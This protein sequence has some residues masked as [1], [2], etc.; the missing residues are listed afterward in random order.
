RDQVP[1]DPI[2]SV[3]ADVDDAAADLV[4]RHDPRRLVGA[5]EED[6]HVRAHVCIPPGTGH[7]EERPALALV[8]EHLGVVD[9]DV[10][11]AELSERRVEQPG[12][13]RFDADV[14]GG[15]Q[16]GPARPADLL[17]CPGDYVRVA[18]VDDDACALPGEAAGDAPADA[19]AGT[20]DDGD[21]V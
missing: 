8:D 7:R 4:P 5:V 9:Q 17:G 20:S 15:L 3:A 6:A 13:L 19:A 1:V 12:D 14:G 2:R 18:V 10:Q 11:G 16:A 21:L